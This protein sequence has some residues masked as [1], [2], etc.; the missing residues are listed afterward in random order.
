M[1]AM[2]KVT[3]GLA[4]AAAVV[5]ATVFAL[6][7]TRG[8]SA[9]DNGRIVFPGTPD[10]S[11]ITQLFSVSPGGSNLKQLTKSGTNSYAPVFSPAGTRIAFVRFGYGIYTMRPDGS[12]L[13]RLSTGA[14]DANPTWSPDGKTVAFLR[15]KGTAWKLW[16]V[17]ATG[18]KPRNLGLQPPAGKPSWITAGLLVPTGG[19]VV[20]VN[21][22]TGRILRYLDASVD[23]V[24]GLQTV[25]ISPNGSWLAYVGTRDPIPGDM[26]CGDGPCQRYGLFLENLK[27]KKKIGKLWVKDAGSAAF[28]PDGK[29][30]AYVTGGQLWL[31]SLGGSATSAIETPGVT[32][33]LT[34]PPAWHR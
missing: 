26:E 11:T 31:R 14:R 15:P 3:V 10:G 32:P 6:V 2:R 4:V 27:A 5:L 16:V 29:R 22:K 25:T 30:V 33:N 23:A 28:S 13:K 21:P 20:S 24:W 1:T 7:A 9:T 18:G 19:D 8:S 34:G 12:G 17:P